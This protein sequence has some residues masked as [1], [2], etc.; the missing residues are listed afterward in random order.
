VFYPKPPPRPKRR[1]RGPSKE[2]QEVY[3]YVTSRDRGC[4]APVVDT[5]ADPCRGPL[6]REH[7]RPGGG[8]MGMRRITRKDA[9]LILC[10]HHHLDG[11]ATSHK[12]EMRDH[13]AR[14][15]PPE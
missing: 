6:H 3:D 13:L 14:V 8:A 2:D 12:Q 10:A 15:E 5:S 9:V 1:R 11:W 4:I 7:V